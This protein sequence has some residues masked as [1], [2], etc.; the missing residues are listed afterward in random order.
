MYW[1]T[2]KLVTL[3]ALVYFGFFCEIKMNHILFFLS[4]LKSFRFTKHVTH[5]VDKI[6]NLELKKKI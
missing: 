1:K 3:M 2:I 6:T 5:N 4:L